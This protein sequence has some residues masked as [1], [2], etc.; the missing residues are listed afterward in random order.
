MSRWLSELS[1]GHSNQSDSWSNILRTINQIRENS[2]FLCFS[3]LLAHA[4]GSSSVRYFL[5]V[6]KR[7]F[8]TMFLVLIPLP[9]IRF[10]RP[11]SFLEMTLGTCHFIA[12]IFYSSSAQ[13]SFELIPILRLSSVLERPL[14]TYH[15][16]AQISNYPSRNLMLASNR[17]ILAFFIPISFDP[18]PRSVTCVDRQAK[19]FVVPGKKVCCDILHLHKNSE[20]I[21]YMHFMKEWPSRG[22]MEH[23]KSDSGRCR[24]H[25]FR[26]PQNQ[27]DHVYQVSA[28]HMATINRSFDYELLFLNLKLWLDY[29]YS[30]RL[31]TKYCD[32]QGNVDLLA[33]KEALFN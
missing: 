3:Q 25:V 23:D 21:A 4:F 16:T 10:L 31:C 9:Q 22:E 20:V 12:Q 32:D 17:N 15:V 29:V 2:S 11:N 33:T 24:V 30:K 8:L 26:E 27:L 1:I 19:S 5:E 18:W 14:G 6:F 28:L 13:V 7:P